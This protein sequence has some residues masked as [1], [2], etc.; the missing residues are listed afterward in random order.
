MDLETFRADQDL[1]YE[2]LAERI[3]VSSARQ[4]QRYALG[5]QWP[6]AEKLA[7]ILRLC[8]GVTIDAIHGRRLAFVREKRD[9]DRLNR[10]AAREGA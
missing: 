1:T 7:E 6:G 4:A 8:P 9:R 2:Q 3:K 5:A 10:S